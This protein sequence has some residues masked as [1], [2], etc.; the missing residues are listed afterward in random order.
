MTPTRSHRQVA[1]R[2][3][4]YETPD[5]DKTRQGKM[6]SPSASTTSPTSPMSPLASP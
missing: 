6:S 1:T 4:G 2:L 5:F 3:A